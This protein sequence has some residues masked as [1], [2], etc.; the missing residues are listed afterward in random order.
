VKKKT[1]VRT[2]PELLVPKDA[3]PWCGAAPAP[4]GSGAVGC[5]VCRRCGAKVLYGGYFV[6][7][8]QRRK[9][10]YAPHKWWAIHSRGLCEAAQ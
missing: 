7:K 3:V 5:M 10:A 4:Q 9:R 2:D 6:V 1:T 8:G